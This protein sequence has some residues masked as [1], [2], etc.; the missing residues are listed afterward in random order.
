MCSTVRD[1]DTSKLVAIEKGNPTADKTQVDTVQD[2]G[3]DTVQEQIGENTGEI[4]KDVLKKQREQLKNI[5]LPS[6]V[7]E[8]KKKKKKKKK[9]TLELVNAAS[10]LMCTKCGAMAT[11]E[12]VLKECTCGCAWYCPGGVCQKGDWKT[13]KKIHKREF[14]VKNT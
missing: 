3:Q 10:P 14:T 12:L 2:T 11:E 1:Y 8:K 9:K 6:V 7:K 5:A 4:H 13:H